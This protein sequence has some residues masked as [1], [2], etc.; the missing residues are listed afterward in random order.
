MST[1]KY[2][3]IPATTFTPGRIRDIAC[4]ILHS[5]DGHQAGDIATLTGQTGRK[6]SAHWYINKSG[7]IF[8]FVQDCDT[9]WHAG[10]V[11]D[12]AYG[13]AGSIGIEQEHMDGEEP[14]TPVQIQAAANL[15]AFLT[16]RH[17]IPVGDNGHHN[18]FSHADVAKPRGRKVDPQNYPWATFWQLY[19]AALANKWEAVQG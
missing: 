6:V 5:T 1:L 7:D 2:K 18:I 3:W 16:Q 15:C 9:A 8:H 12:T 4:I 10:L 13:N 11:F 17:R 19:A 14:W